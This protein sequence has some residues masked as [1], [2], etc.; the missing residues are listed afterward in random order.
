MST[1]TLNGIPEAATASEGVEAYPNGNSA[2]NYEDSA[3]HATWTNLPVYEAEDGS[4][5]T[6]V[7]KETT[8]ASGYTVSYGA[9]GATYVSTSGT[10]TNTLNETSISVVKKDS[11]DNH[12]LSGAQFTLYRVTTE[13]VVPANEGEPTTRRVETPYPDATNSVKTT[14]NNGTITFTNLIDG[15]YMLVE[16]QTPAGYNAQ[17]QAIEFSISGGVVSYTPG[18]SS[19]SYESST[20]TFTVPNTP[21]VELP[22]TGGTGTLPYTLT[23]LTLLLGA[24]LILYYRRRRREQN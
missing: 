2:D 5:I 8:R 12:A 23:G 21:G 4:A 7:V 10:I 22:A 11:T 19:V 17:T 6:Y 14:G 18:S 20:N 16:T 1:I 3:W 13:T 9:A 15:D 24:S